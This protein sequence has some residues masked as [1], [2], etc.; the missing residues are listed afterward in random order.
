MYFHVCIECNI[1]TAYG[2][3]MER[4]YHYDMKNIN[5]FAEDIVKPYLKQQKFHYKGYTLEDKNIVRFL[6]KQSEKSMRELVDNLNNKVSSGVLAYFSSEDIFNSDD[7]M[8]DI[9][10]TV[11][12]KMKS[13]IDSEVGN[14]SQVLSTDRNVDRFKV[15]VVH[16]HDKSALY[17]TARFFEKLGLEPIILNEQP[18]SGKTI[19]EKIEEYT[20][21][22]FGVVLYSPCDIGAKNKPKPEYKNRARQNVVFE[23]GYLMGKIG[24][25]NVCALVKGD[26]E[27]P[28]DIS[29]I[30]YISMDDNGAWKISLAK[31][32]QRSGYEVDMNKI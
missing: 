14:T 1:K 13:V 20:N 22:G 4:L 10:I 21:V 19:I 27:I 18:S 7:C 5:D 31:E 3:K 6:I 9:T 23:H 26:I 8:K 28:T 15:F 24:R 16:G 30:V 29:G 25:S 17:E 32:L 12:K 2:N 11:L